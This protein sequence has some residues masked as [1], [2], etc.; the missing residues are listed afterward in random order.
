MCSNHVVEVRPPRISQKPQ[1]SLGSLGLYDETLVRYRQAHEVNGGE[2]ILPVR[3]SLMRYFAL[4]M[5]HQGHATCPAHA[6]AAHVHEHEHAFSTGE[7]R[8]VRDGAA[9][10]SMQVLSP[11]LCLSVNVHAPPAAV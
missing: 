1:T 5:C 11:I 8:T 4:L 9:F 3:V 10:R 6:H 2:H 7:A